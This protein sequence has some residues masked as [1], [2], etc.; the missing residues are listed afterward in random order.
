MS[1]SERIRKVIDA[2]DRG[3]FCIASLPVSLEIAADIADVPSLETLMRED[4]TTAAALD[5][6]ADVY[7]FRERPAQWDD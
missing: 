4:K 5:D 1:K 2:V 3:T 6:A 7:A